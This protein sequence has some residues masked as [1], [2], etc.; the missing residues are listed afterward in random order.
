MEEMA[1]Q[2]AQVVENHRP[3][4]TGSIGLFFRKVYNLAHLRLDLLCKNMQITEED[5]KR[6]IWTTFEY[7]LQHH[8]DLMKDRHIDTLLMCS[9]YIISKVSLRNSIT[10]T[11]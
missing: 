3:K 9:L 5:V 4:R 7:T 6:K 2:P 8:T 1:E 11:S 10:R